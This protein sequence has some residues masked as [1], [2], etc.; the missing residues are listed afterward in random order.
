[1]LGER[2]GFTVMAR[3]SDAD[4]SG[5]AAQGPGYQKRTRLHLHQSRTETREDRKAREMD[6]NASLYLSDVCGG[7]AT[8]RVVTGFDAMRW[9]ISVA[10]SRREGCKA[11]RGE[12]RK[13]PRHGRSNAVK[14]TLRPL[15]LYNLFR[16]VF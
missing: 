14:I 15:S 11:G 16:R 6:R 12:I 2:E 10:S 5:G 1:V 3:F 8:N 13:R 4:I 7:L 9:T